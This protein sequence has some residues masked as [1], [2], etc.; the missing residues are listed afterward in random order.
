M[1]LRDSGLRSRVWGCNL[2]L[3]VRDVGMRFGSWGVRFR[4]KVLWIGIQ[5]LGCKVHGLGFMD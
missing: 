5:V 2:G 4:V 1:I 3:M